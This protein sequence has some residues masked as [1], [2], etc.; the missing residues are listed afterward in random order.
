MNMCIGGDLYSQ[1]RE[2][3]TGTLGS[4][5]GFTNYDKIYVVRLA[6]IEFCQE[7]NAKFETWASAWRAFWPVFKTTKE[8][9]SL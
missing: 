8:Y 3:S 4:L 5:A 6:F 9:K 1:S 2:L 7:N